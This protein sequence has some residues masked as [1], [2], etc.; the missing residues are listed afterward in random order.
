MWRRKSLNMS[1]LRNGILLKCNST[2]GS[3]Y[4]AWKIMADIFLVIFFLHLTPLVSEILVIIDIPR[5]RQVVVMNV[6]VADAM[7]IRESLH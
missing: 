5:A 2:W 3:D 4:C 7:L 6:Y 1:F